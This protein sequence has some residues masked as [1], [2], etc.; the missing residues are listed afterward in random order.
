MPGQGQTSHLVEVEQ[1]L[2]DPPDLS[3]P[4]A[5]AARTRVRAWTMVST[6]ETDARTTS[7]GPICS[8]A[9][10]GCAPAGRASIASAATVKIPSTTR[11]EGFI[12]SL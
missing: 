6:R 10:F 7:R 4:L 1:P 9:T 8:A 3:P 5:T 12:Q 2:G 11:Q